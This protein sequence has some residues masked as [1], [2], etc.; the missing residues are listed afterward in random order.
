MSK[1]GRIRINPDE[2]YVDTKGNRVI[3]LP[4]Y[5]QTEETPVDTNWTDLKGYRF[6]SKFQTENAED[7]WKD[8]C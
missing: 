8:F 5:L 1:S 4:E 7:C 6:A 2:N 3:G